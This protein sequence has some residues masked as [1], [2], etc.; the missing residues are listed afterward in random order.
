MSGRPIPPTG[1][2][3]RIFS[4]VQGLSWFHVGRQLPGPSSGKRSAQGPAGLP[5]EGAETV[6]GEAGVAGTHE[7]AL[8]AGRGHMGRR[9][10]ARRPL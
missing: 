6:A 4:V 1:C 2:C 9:R 5:A 7:A 3:L 10:C 8:L